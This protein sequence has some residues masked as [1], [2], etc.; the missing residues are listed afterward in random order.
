MGKIKKK[1]VKNEDPKKESESAQLTSVQIKSILKEPKKQVSKKKSNELSP[2]AVRRKI[3]R[4]RKLHKSPVVHSEVSR[5]GEQT[6]KLKVVERLNKEL[7]EQMDIRLLLDRLNH[8]KA[9]LAVNKIPM[10]HKRPKTSKTM[11]QEQL[12]GNQKLSSSKSINTVVPDVSH[13]IDHSNTT[14][15]TTT[16][17]ATKRSLIFPVSKH[18]PLSSHVTKNKPVKIPL[19]ALGKEPELISQAMYSRMFSSSF[20]YCPKTNQHLYGDATQAKPVKD[21]KHTENAKY[22]T[23]Q[24]ASNIKADTSF[25]LFKSL[26]SL[27]FSKG[28]KKKFNREEQKQK[29]Q[30]TK[31]IQEDH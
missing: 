27:P 12:N 26:K 2:N 11:K 16:A 28:A 13:S 3:R 29:E 22:L 8:K 17:T 31:P 30:A 9:K 6:N 20:Q 25:L 19:L 5:V 15:T 1:L 7:N 21:V 14:T 24:S 4:L 18:V 23:T 10:P